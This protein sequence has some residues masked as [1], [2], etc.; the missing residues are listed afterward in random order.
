MPLND[1][2][3]DYDLGDFGGDAL[4]VAF[5][6]GNG[7]SVGTPEPATNVLI[8]AGLLLISALCRRY[9]RRKVA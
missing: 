6:F 3:L 9:S 8:G 5:D 4:S 2:T 1:F 7:G